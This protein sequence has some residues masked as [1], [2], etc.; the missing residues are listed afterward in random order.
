MLKLKTQQCPLLLPHFRLTLSL[1]HRP[2]PVLGRDNRTTFQKSAI[3]VEHTTSICCTPV[4]G[5]RSIDMILWG[6][7]VR[8]GRAE[9]KQLPTQ[10]GDVDGGGEEE[11]NISEMG[12]SFQVI[13]VCRCQRQLCCLSPSLP[14]PLPL[15]HSRHPPASCRV[16]CRSLC[17]NFVRCRR[18]GVLFNVMLANLNSAQLSSVW[19]ALLWIQRRRLGRRRRRSVSWTWAPWQ[20]LN[21]TRTR[22]YPR[23]QGRLRRRRRRRRSRRSLSAAFVGSLSFSRSCVLGPCCAKT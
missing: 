11:E 5:V 9:L 22:G 13:S 1:L 18:H 6:R 4:A 17:A 14:L 20:I 19:L 2:C 3:K 12:D 23:T 7:I 10:G 8:V 16:A 21:E 15:P